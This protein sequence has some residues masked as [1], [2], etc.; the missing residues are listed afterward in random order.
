MSIYKEINSSDLS[1]NESTTH[2]QYI[3]TGSGQSTTAGQIGWVGYRSG[4]VYQS[5]LETFN[6]NYWDSLQM[7][8]YL[9]GSQHIPSDKFYNPAF[10]L[11]PYADRYPIHKSKFHTM[12]TGSFLTIPQNT[13]GRFIKPNSFKLVDNSSDYTLNI[14]DD[15][16]GNLYADNALVSRSINSLGITGSK[17]SSLNYV[18]N[19]FYRYGLAVIT[20]TGSFSGSATY[21]TIASRSWTCSFSSSKTIYTS[22]Y[23]VTVNPTEFTHTVNPTSYKRE[24]GS[25]VDHY[26]NEL[27]GSEF[28][29]YFNTIGFYDKRDECVMIARYPQ[30]IKKRND[31]PVSFKVKMDW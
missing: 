27:T 10:T 14:K 13:F 28:T 20:E 29:P 22:E 7:N 18:G 31:I 23:N 21:K 24:T 25:R 8:F 11:S 5:A 12:K 19:I 1:I 9:S 4:S 6:V 15:G 17:S 30:N 2:K 16:F 3:V 26:R